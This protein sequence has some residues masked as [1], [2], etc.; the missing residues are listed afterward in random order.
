MNFL[1]DADWRV[2]TVFPNTERLVVIKLREVFESFGDAV[3]ADCLVTTEK[4]KPQEDYQGNVVV[5]NRN[6]GALADNGFYRDDIFT[7]QIWGY[8]DDETAHIAS[9]T[10]GLFQTLYGDGIAF[11]SIEEP[12]SRIP[13]DGE[14]YLHVITGSVLVAGSTFRK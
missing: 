12:E 11:C 7:I 13:I 4:P 2:I 9:L 6:G 5:I 1:E 8:D 3:L 14:G 10:E